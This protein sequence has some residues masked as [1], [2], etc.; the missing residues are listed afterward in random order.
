MNLS[1]IMITVMLVSA[2]G[3]YL[4]DDILPQVIARASGNDRTFYTQ[5]RGWLRGASIVG[6][7]YCL[8]VGAVVFTSSLA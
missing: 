4:A 3:L 8:I 5:A 2:L 1:G 6:G 7:L